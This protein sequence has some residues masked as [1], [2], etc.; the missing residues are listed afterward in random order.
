MRSAYKRQMGEGLRDIAELTATLVEFL[1]EQAQMVGST[2]ALAHRKTPLVEPTGPSW[3][4][5]IPERAGGEGAL[6]SFKAVVIPVPVDHAVVAKEFADC[7]ERL[8]PYRI[9]R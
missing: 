3:T 8:Q 2:H 4:F 7:V 6:P 5:D 9:R 1:G